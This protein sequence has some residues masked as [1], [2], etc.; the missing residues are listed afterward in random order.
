MSYDPRQGSS[1][2]LG[3]DDD[4]SEVREAREVTRVTRGDNARTTRLD[5]ARTIRAEAPRT[6]RLDAERTA[7]REGAPAVQDSMPTTIRRPA[8]Q[9]VMAPL[10]RRESVPTPRVPVPSPAQ[11]PYV[12]GARDAYVP[13]RASR[14]AGPVAALR[15]LGLWLVA[16]ALRL[17]AI[18]L[19]AVVVASAVVAGPYRAK[20]VTA[21]GELSWLLEL[22][23]ISGRFVTETPFGGV[24]RGDVALA[25][26]IL[27][28]ADWLCLR[29][30]A[31]L[32]ARR[33]RG[34]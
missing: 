13:Q 14:F 18:A 24:L 9:Q 5:A 19:A 10:R 25:S 2:Y 22:P 26:L 1:P 8:R 16:L 21:L 17:A 33:E 20:L 30:R 29:A 23:L 15:S 28:C 34:V 32:R 12:A 6:T 7:Y 4:E 11:E 27:F 31:S 3:M